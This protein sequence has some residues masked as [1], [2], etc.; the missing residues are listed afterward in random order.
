M[1]QGRDVGSSVA[2]VLVILEDVELKALACTE[3]N[4]YLL[5]RSTLRR[6]FFCKAAH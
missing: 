4:V 6:S 2:V 1:S 3:Y 5:I